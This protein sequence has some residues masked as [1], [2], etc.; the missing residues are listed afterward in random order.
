MSLDKI[1]ATHTERHH[2]LTCK[3]LRT[4]AELESERAAPITTASSTLRMLTNSGGEWKMTCGGKRGWTNTQDNKSGQ[5]HK[6]TIEN[7]VRFLFWHN[8]FCH[9]ITTYP[10]LVCW[11][12]PALFQSKK[13]HVSVLPRRTGG[14]A[15]SCFACPSCWTIDHAFSRG[16][17]FVAIRMIYDGK[18]KGAGGGGLC[19]PRCA[20]VRTIISNQP[21]DGCSPIEPIP[22]RAVKGSRLNSRMRKI[23]RTRAIQWARRILIHGQCGTCC[24]HGFQHGHDPIR[25]MRLI[26]FHAHMCVFVSHTHRCTVSHWA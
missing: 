21:W 25:T 13:R 4:K 18:T 10:G 15:S 19:W 11:A 2:H 23:L 22:T 14:G 12:H 26:W 9:Q 3:I 1:W 24:E 6:K 8:F 20:Q 7:Q 17:S 16:R 5:W